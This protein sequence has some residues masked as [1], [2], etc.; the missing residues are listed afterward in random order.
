MGVRGVMVVVVC[1]R[2]EWVVGWLVGWVGGW[3]GARRR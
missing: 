2:R 3:L 1:V